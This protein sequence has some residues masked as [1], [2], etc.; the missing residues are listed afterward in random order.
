MRKG[1]QLD[2]QE[3]VCAS[4]PQ[5]GPV[6][7]Q[8][9]KHGDLSVDLQHVYERQAWWYVRVFKPYWAG[10]DRWVSGTC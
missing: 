2:C 1:A 6:T 3:S 4:V 7:C 5:G 9:G 8:L 10:R